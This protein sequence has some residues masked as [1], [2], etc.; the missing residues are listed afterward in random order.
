MDMLEATA[1]HTV[2]ILRG[3]TLYNVFQK[4][5]GLVT[6]SSQVDGTKRF[7]HMVDSNSD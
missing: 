5:F 7:R 2:T 4:A 1:Y 3:A 6:D